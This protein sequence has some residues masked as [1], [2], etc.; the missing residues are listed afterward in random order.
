MITLTRPDASKF[1]IDPDKITLIEPS[2]G[3][4]APTTKTVIRIDGENHAVRE[5][6]AQID[7]MRAAK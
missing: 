2:D 5:T 1:E 7:A 4:W 6:M 3:T